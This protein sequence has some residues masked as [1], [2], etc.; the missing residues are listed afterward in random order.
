MK[1]AILIA[2]LF[3]LIYP[4]ANAQLWKLRRFELYG[5]IG[6]SQIYSDIGGFTPGDNALGLKDIII[7]QTRFNL[8]TGFRF[9]IIEKVS[10][11]L[12]FNYGFL[13]AS[14]GVGSNE[15]RD[16]A[17]STSLIEP[18]LT[19]EY[20]ILKNSAESSYRFV[21]G[22]GFF[23]S[24][25]DKSDLYV[26]TG[27]GPAIYSVKGNDQLEPVMEKSSGVTAVIPL[28]L[29]INYLISP[30]TLVG[31]D[32][33]IRYTTTDYLDGY[34]SQ[35]SKSNDVYSFITFVFTQKLKTSEKGLPT[36]RR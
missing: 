8:T 33:G 14:D 29:G 22:S 36:F 9:R 31:M 2:I 27:F 7:S 11:K 34:T 26:Y 6:T 3:A 21:K 20:Y 17:F 16:Y 19:G 24:F 10:V 15:S 32:I 25:L 18:L 4:L 1:R 35:Y 12:S 13:H 5:G 23:G 30:T 28:G